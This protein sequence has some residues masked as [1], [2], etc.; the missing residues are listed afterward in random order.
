MKR[1]ASSNRKSETDLKLVPRSDFQKLLREDSEKDLTGA[2]ASSSAGDDGGDD[3]SDDC[4]IVAASFGLQT[5]PS[6]AT[7]GVLKRLRSTSALG[8]SSKD[9]IR[10]PCAIDLE[11]HL[12]ACCAPALLPQACEVRAAWPLRVLVCGQARSPI[13]PNVMF[14]A[15]DDVD[16]VDPASPNN[17]RLADAPQSPASVKPEEQI[18]SP[19]KAASFGVSDASGTSPPPGN[20]GTL[21]AG[22]GVAATGQLDNHVPPLPASLVDELCSLCRKRRRAKKQKNCLTCKADLAAAKRESERVGELEYFNGLVKAGGPDLEDFLHEYIKNNGESR[23]R[24]SQRSRFDW[25]KYKEARRI[26]SV[27][28]LGFKARGL[29]REVV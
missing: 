17:S 9:G 15:P 22:S 25:I 14:A 26:Q 16:M 21:A 27:F 13:L 19:E 5:R 20:S 7:A 6:K 23:R 4:Q 10:L 18:T 8:S 3:S 28:R 12:D 24:Y 2:P 11:L 1:P 29:V